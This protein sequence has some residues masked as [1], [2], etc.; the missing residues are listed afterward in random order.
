[1]KLEN[2]KAGD[3]IVYTEKIDFYDLT[4]YIIHVKSVEKV[5][6]GYKINATFILEHW[7][8]RDYYGLANHTSI[9]CDEEEESQIR[10]ARK[11]EIGRFHIELTNFY[12]RLSNFIQS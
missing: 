2:I 8:H 11:S 9:I 7:I 4:T 1:M 3:Y 10:K 5:K 12:N 6:A